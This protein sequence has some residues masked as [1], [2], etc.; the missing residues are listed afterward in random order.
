MST[1]TI[2]IISTIYTSSTTTITFPNEIEH[3]RSQQYKLIAATSQLNSHSQRV[4]LPFPLLND[5]L[6]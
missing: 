5:A 4:A 3:I 2:G 1:F 6:G